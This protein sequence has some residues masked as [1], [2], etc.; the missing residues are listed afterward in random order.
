MSRD[1]WLPF[2]I[3]EKADTKIERNKTKV[4]VSWHR[5]FPQTLQYYKKVL[6]KS[7]LVEVVQGNSRRQMTCK[8]KK[9]NL[10]S[11]NALTLCIWVFICK[12]LSYIL[13]WLHSSFIHYRNCWRIKL[14]L[15][16]AAKSNLHEPRRIVGLNWRYIAKEYYIVWALPCGIIP[17]LP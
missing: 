11:C 4:L 16:K 8:Q 5:E 14:K 6:L 1:V 2:L 15:V 17:Y 7:S 13:G 12:I 10:Y 9:P 3:I